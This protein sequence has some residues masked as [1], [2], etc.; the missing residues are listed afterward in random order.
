MKKWSNKQLHRIGET[1]AYLYPTMEVSRQFVKRAE[2]NPAQIAFHNQA[3]LNWF[4]ILEFAEKQNKITEV[5]DTA[6]EDYPEHKDL[7]NLRLGV[8]TPTLPSPELKNA[9]WQ[10]PEKALLEKILGAKSTLVNISY[11]EQGVDK[12]RSVARLLLPDGSSGTGFIIDGNILITNNHL[13]PDD[14]TA[15]KSAAQFNFQ[16]TLAGS[17]AAAEMFGFDPKSFFLTSKDN[18]WTAVK[19]IE[20][21]QSKWGALTL[22]ANVLSVGDH[23]NIIQHAGGGQ[24]QISLTAN[25]VAYLGNSRVQYLTDTLPGSS[26]SPVFDENWNVVALHQR[27]GWLIEPEAKTKNTFYR[28]E[29]IA[30]ECV[31]QGIK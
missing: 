19:L 24:K 22:T 15:A 2:L 28:N 27:G 4:Q 6:M 10:G 31:M 30:I 29:G 12:A 21:A 7:Q 26:G 3:S 5:I 8:L 11:L 1:L 25:T 9:E 16:K 20:D 23:V 13:L 17:D 18:D 14:I